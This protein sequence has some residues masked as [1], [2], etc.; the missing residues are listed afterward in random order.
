MQ[1][2]NQSGKPGMRRDVKAAASLAGL[3]GLRPP[4]D[5]KTTYSF[6]KSSFAFKFLAAGA[7]L[8]PVQLCGGAVDTAHAFAE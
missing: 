2:A 4:K 5:E 6:R 3:I 1:Y 8:A 7:M